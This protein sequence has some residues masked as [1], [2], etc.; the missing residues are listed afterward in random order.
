MA[1]SSKEVDYIAKMNGI[2]EAEKKKGMV[3]LR[4]CCLP[5][6]D[7]DD[8]KSAQLLAKAYCRIMERE[9]GLKP[10]AVRYF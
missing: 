5:S 7:C 10:E 9:N 6:S 2:I 8:E 1:E 4:F 3:G